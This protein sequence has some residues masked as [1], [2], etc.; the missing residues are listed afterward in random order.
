[1]AEQHDE[2]ESSSGPGK[3][4]SETQADEQLE[5]EAE[6]AEGGS[7]PPS[8]APAAAAPKPKKKKK[9]PVDAAAEPIRDR[10][11]RLRE[12]AAGKRKS[13]LDERRAP[14]RNLEAGE[15][16]DDALART[17][18][19]AGE[20]LKRNFNVVQ[21]FIIVGLVAWIG[22]AVYS[23]RAGRAAEKASAQLN[24][25]IRAEDARIGGDDSKP[26]PQTGIVDTRPAY[27]TNADRL[28]AAEQQYRA[29]A[30]GSS[31]S[32]AS[33]LA[34]LGLA[35]VLY[36]Q[37]KYADAKASYEAV[38]DSKLAG[39]D[40]NVKGRALEGIGMCL[41][42]QGDKD[43][44]EKAF[45]ELS[46]LDTL[47]FGALGAY[48]QARL[49]V[50]ANNPEKAKELLKDAQKKLDAA[51]EASEAKKTLGSPPGY[52]QQ[53]VRDLLR[54]VDPS[55]ISAS[56][57]ALTSEQL[58]EL[59]EQ[60]GAPGGDGKGMSSEKLQELLKQMAKGGAKAPAA[61]APPASAP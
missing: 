24:A 39:Q 2:T 51:A 52:L 16:V 35:S 54:Q 31:Q 5:G 44:A 22:Y 49:A 7:A 42:S 38:K 56:P 57:N 41:E 8:D 11:R 47:G 14:T 59:Q 34:K 30:Q 18:Q 60:M 43:G 21:W 19:A 3:P 33:T 26:D 37:G 13:R 25:A 20:W 10:N 55:A 17:S 4:D 48:H 61:P 32:A 45:R 9:R 46:N 28:R 23:Y 29:I 1:V 50:A 58:Q 6:S 12:E 53:A 15:I 27:P 36:D 40:A